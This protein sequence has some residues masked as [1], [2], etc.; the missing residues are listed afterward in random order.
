MA[1]VTISF[2]TGVLFD[3]MM[4][5]GPLH[6]RHQALAGRLVRPGPLDFTPEEAIAIRDWLA[7]Q[8]EG[9]I[10]LRDRHG[11]IGEI[12]RALRILRL[13]PGCGRPMTSDEALA[14]RCT[15]CAA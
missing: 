9:F 5:G 7:Q 6:P 14:G 15:Y 2:P 13:C 8:P 12:E 3:V 1:T 11:A 10:D 4:R